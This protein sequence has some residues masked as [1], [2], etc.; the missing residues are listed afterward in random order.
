MTIAGRNRAR[1]VAISIM[2][3]ISIL[4][5]TLAIIIF[6]NNNFENYSNFKNLQ[7]F[8]FFLTEYRPDVVCFAIIIMPILSLTFLTYIYF[9]FR[10]T[11]ALEIAFF[12]V[13]I[14][15]IGFES[16]RLIFPLNSFSGMLLENIS[17]L[18]RIVYFSRLVAIFSLFIGSIYALKILTQQVSYIL[19][20]IIFTAFLLTISMPIS[21]FNMNKFFLFGEQS[22]YSYKFILLLASFLACLNYFLAYW[23]KKAKEYLG[24]SIGSAILLMGYWLLIYTSSYL[25]LISGVLFFVI[26]AVKYIKNIHNYHLWV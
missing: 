21:N 13:F 5:I 14:F 23:T 22:A 18:S 7:F 2:S 9:A 6:V 19:F 24:A 11:H 1:I 10:K 16:L 15:S 12:V 4:T 17:L 25:F 20:F 26:G 8:N 3:V